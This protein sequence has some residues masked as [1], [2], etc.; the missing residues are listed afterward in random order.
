MALAALICKRSLSVIAGEGPSTIVAHC[1]TSYDT[2]LIEKERQTFS[3]LSVQFECGLLNKSGNGNIWAGSKVL[4]LKAHLCLLVKS[5]QSLVTLENC[6]WTGINLDPVWKAASS[7]ED[8]EN[9]DV[10]FDLSALI[11]ENCQLAVSQA[12]GPCV[13][14]WECVSLYVWVCVRE[15]RGYIFYSFK[16]VFGPGLCETVS[17]CVFVGVTQM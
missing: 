16:A 1:G 7:Q 14:V 5:Q 8:E 12:L 2:T 9:V 11:L 3:W 10:N 15:L 4:L 17:L 13:F 6:P